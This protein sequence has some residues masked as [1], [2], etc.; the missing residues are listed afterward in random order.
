MAPMSMPF[1]ISRASV[2]CPISS[3]SSVPSFPACSSSTSMPPGCCKGPPRLG[4]GRQGRREGFA[5]LVEEL[6]D[7]VDVVVDDDPAALAVAVLRHLRPR[8][9]L[10][11]GTAT[12]AG[13]LSKG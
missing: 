10:H 7:V 6:G 9:L 12:R 4:A 8:V 11:C 1:C 2:E 13:A 5:N 3:K